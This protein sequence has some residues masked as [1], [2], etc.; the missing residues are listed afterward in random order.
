MVLNI[1]NNFGDPTFPEF[2]PLLDDD[3]VS[4]TALILMENPD[5]KY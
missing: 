1:F 3:I 5:G 2:V 4:L